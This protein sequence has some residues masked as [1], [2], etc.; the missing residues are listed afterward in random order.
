M[1][2]AKL[3]SFLPLLALCDCGTL[4][5]VPAKDADG[6]GRV[7]DGLCLIASCGLYSEKVILGFC[8]ISS[9]SEPFCVQ[10]QMIF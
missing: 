1:L 8:L 6:K 5:P 2:L 10:I 4:P 3:S 9:F 7:E